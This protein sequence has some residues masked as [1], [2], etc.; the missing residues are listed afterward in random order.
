MAKITPD[1]RFHFPEGD[2]DDLFIIANEDGPVYLA[3]RR[4]LQDLSLPRLDDLW[5]ASTAFR[6]GTLTNFIQNSGKKAEVVI[7]ESSLRFRANRWC[8]PTDCDDD[9]TVDDGTVDEQE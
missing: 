6:K 4:E 7:T 3:T 9:G 5:K 8:C 2:G 1:E